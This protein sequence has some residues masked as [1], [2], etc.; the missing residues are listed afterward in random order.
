[1]KTRVD[2]HVHP[3]FQTEF[4]LTPMCFSWP[5]RAKLCQ[6]GKLDHL[7]RRFGPILAP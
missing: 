5:G 3:A 4:W 2:A 6:L 1:M 7:A